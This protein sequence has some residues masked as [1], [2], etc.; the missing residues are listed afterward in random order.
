[1][2]DQPAVLEQPLCHLQVH[3]IVLDQKD[4][5]AAMPGLQELTRRRLLLH[6][7]YV[8]VLPGLAQ[9]HREPEGCAGTQRTVDA[10]RALHHLHQPLADGQSQSA[11]TVG[12]RV[13]AV[14]LLEGLED[15]TLILGRDADAG[16]LNLESQHDPCRAVLKQQGTHRD[17]AL[18]G[19]LGRVAGEVE[20]HLAQPPGVTPHHHAEQLGRQFDRQRKL[21]LGDLLADQGVQVV[22]DGIELEFGLHQ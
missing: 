14:D 20:Q 10:Y 22:Q 4:V 13:G 19:E 16:V 8:Q 6:W 2:H 3:G 12:T 21:R 17:R 9:L 15:S 11:S 18:R 5:G 7:R 1:M